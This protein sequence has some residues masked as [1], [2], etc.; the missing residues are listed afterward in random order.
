MGAHRGFEEALFSTLISCRFSSESSK[1]LFRRCSEESRRPLNG[2]PPEFRKSVFRSLT[3]LTAASTPAKYLQKIFNNFW[4]AYIR[5]TSKHHP[6]RKTLQESARRILWWISRW[7]LRRIPRYIFGGS[8][9]AS[10]QQDSSQPSSD[11]QKC[12]VQSN[13]P[14]RCTKMK[15]FTPGNTIKRL[16]RRVFFTLCK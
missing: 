16:V 7:V 3:H 15:I 1:I 9:G 11:P 14:P 4:G 6:E 8:C 13:Y 5:C 2:T 10:L 12:A